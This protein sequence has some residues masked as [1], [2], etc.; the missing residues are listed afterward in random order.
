M[1]VA[2]HAPSPMVGVVV[3]AKRAMQRAVGSIDA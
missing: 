1:A 3:G 2:V